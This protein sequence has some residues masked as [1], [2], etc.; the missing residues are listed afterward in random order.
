MINEAV[1]IPVIVA[2][3]ELFKGLGLPKKF[4]S[5]VSVI[6]GAIIGTL[7]IE[8]NDIKTNFFLGIVYGLS[9]SG[10]YST[11]KNSIEGLI[12]IKNKK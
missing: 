3:V 2:L 9:A 4:A 12:D 11:T 5:L 8:N 7:Y 1:I 6:L 10:L